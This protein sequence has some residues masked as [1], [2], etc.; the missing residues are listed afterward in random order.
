MRLRLRRIHLNIKNDVRLSQTLATLERL[1]DVDARLALVRQ[2]K[3]TVRLIDETDEHTEGEDE[4]ETDQNDD[5]DFC[6]L[7]ETARRQQRFGPFPSP[8]GV[9]HTYGEDE[10]SKKFEEEEKTEDIWVHLARFISRLPNLMDLVYDCGQQVPPRL[11]SALRDHCP[12]TRLHLH[13]FSLRSLYQV[14]DDFHEIDLDEYALATS[15]NLYSLNMR[16]STWDSDGRVGYNEDA[17]LHM[18]AGLAPRLSMSPWTAR[19]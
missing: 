5:Y 6:L 4:G 8:C 2:V 1:S 11:L 15:S 3:L 13:T 18:V 16:W 17:V 7:L 9:Y 10:S 12:T 14:R 19:A